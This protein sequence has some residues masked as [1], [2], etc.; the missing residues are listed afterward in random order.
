MLDDEQLL[1]QY[2]RDRS[3]PAF[4]ELVSRH[5]DLVYSVALRITNGDTHLAQDI[6]QTVFMDLAQKAPEL[7]RGV[8]LPCWLHKHTFFKATT[9]VRA[10]RRRRSREQIA[11]DMKSLEEDPQH[12]WESVAP[13]LDA[14]LDEL[15]PV[16]RDAA[17]LRYLKKMDL[18]AVG[19]SLG[20]TEAAAQKRVGRAVDRL[21]SSLAKRGIKVGAPSLVLSVTGHAIHSAPAGLAAAITAKV[22]LTAGTLG[23][24]AGI[25]AAKGAALITT[26]KAAVTA[27][28]VAM[29]TLGY[30]WHSHSHTASSLSAPQTNPID[31]IA[32]AKDSLAAGPADNSVPAPSPQSPASPQPEEYVQVSA[33]FDLEYFTR[34]STNE[35]AGPNHFFFSVLC[36]AG[37]QKWQV[38][39]RN[40][41]GTEMLCFADGTNFF[42]GLHPV[43]PTPKEAEER[44]SKHFGLAIVPFKEAASNASVRVFPSPDGAP[45]GN[46]WVNLPWLVFCSGQYLKRPGR[47]IPV[48]TTFIPHTPDAFAYADKSE[49]FD[50]GFGLPKTV[51][52]YASEAQFE[53]SVKRASFLGNPDV[54]LWRRAFPWFK[55]G[56]EAFN[57][58][59]LESTNFA[60]RELPLR[61]EFSQP[62]PSTDGSSTVRA[63]GSGR[64]TD[65][66]V[67]EAPESPF[68]TTLSR[69]VVDYRFNSYEKQIQALTYRD[70]NGALL[71]VS[72][73]DLQKKLAAR[74]SKAASDPATVR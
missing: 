46:V 11:S 33:D 64:I 73:P 65:L 47:V 66:R 50:D 72:S 4:S 40:L 7:P 57:Y 37:R 74:L 54:D 34:G 26:E 61:F 48:P 19:Q 16:D 13:Y 51:H 56:V 43:E 10:E 14:S 20:I 68:A 62:V 1:Q 39:C 49:V 12:V 53:K 25:P 31:S 52:L 67:S 30:F 27:A 71:P 70:T 59:V 58:T 18:R 42:E 44:I 6:A 41:N 60:G 5:L 38:Y 15:N 24:T 28:L 3:E 45:V 22:S 36:T 55:D 35:P 9:A 21:R 2:A 63:K 23:L 32:S 29:L 69:T 8:V 17:V